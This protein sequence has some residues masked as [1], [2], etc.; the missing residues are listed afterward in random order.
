M[1]YRITN[2]HRLLA[3]AAFAYASI[4]TSAQEIKVAGETIMS[5]ADFGITTNMRTWN[6]AKDDVKASKAETIVEDY[7]MLVGKRSHCHNVGKQR[8]YTITNAAGDALGLDIRTFKDGYAFRYFISDLKEGEK[9]T[10]EHSAYHIPA[11][12]NRWMQQYDGPGYEHFFPLCVGGVSPEGEKVTRWGY[13]ALFEFVPQTAH[14]AGSYMLISDTYSPAQHTPGSILTN[15]P[16]DRNTYKVQNFNDN[17]PTEAHTADGKRQWISAWRV[18]ICGTLSQVVESTLHNDVATPS[19]IDSSWIDTGLASWIY[20]AYNHGSQEYDIL[21]RYVDLAVEMHWPYTLVDAEWDVMRGGNVEQLCK[22]A[23]S[24]GVKP[25]IWYNSTTNWTGQWAP[26]PQGLL[27]DPEDCDREFAKIASWGV[28]GVKIDFFTEDDSKTTAY[29]HRLLECAAKHHLLVNFHGGTFP[30][31][32]QRTYPNLISCEA[33]YGAEWYNNNAR[34]TNRAARHNATLPFTRNVIGSMDYTPCTFT[35]SQH[36]HI[37]SHA[38]ELA[39]PILFESGIQHMADRPES[40]LGLPETVKSLLSE[41][42]S[43]WDETRLLAGYPGEYVVMARRKGATWYI[44]GINGK[45]EPQTISFDTSSLKAKAK[46]ILLIADGASQTEFSI[47][48]NVPMT[49]KYAI[50]TQPRG[51]FVIKL[52]R[53]N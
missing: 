5:P 19:S 7:D 24:K 37:T 8:T 3:F 23:V 44:A 42:P 38:H 15:T 20:W 25:M 40:Y 12:C 4:T 1:K 10:E 47:K 52:Q 30:H 2:T 45:D 51:G 31:G 18:I 41:L 35:D 49:K 39:L 13:P 53:K 11:H 9:V 6:A 22:Y 17:E 33:V 14:N 34:L 32:W 27:N 16:A 36:P 28:A 26:T 43:T 48:E 21:K 50:A 46:D 29:Y